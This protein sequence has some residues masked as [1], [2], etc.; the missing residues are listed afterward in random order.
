MGRDTRVVGGSYGKKGDT[1]DGGGC[2]GGVGVVLSSIVGT[3]SAGV[4]G[5]GT[6]LGEGGRDGKE[7]G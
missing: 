5:S 3:E 1:V 4:G 2:R 7:T 6:C